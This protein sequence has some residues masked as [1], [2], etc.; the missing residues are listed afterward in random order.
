M[1]NAV[2]CC[3]KCGVVP[4]VTLF[5]DAPSTSRQPAPTRMVE[6]ELR[7]PTHTVPPAVDADVSVR[8]SKRN[9]LMKNRGFKI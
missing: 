9:T 2:A 8:N 6:H 7:T 4:P 3:E 1:D 5:D